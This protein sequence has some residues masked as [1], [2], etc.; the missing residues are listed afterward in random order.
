M[1]TKPD[2]SFRWLVWTLA[3]LG[4]AVDQVGKYGVFQYLHDEARQHGLTA[5]RVIIPPEVLRFHVEFKSEPFPEGAS[6]LQTWSGELQPR[7][8]KGAFLGFGNGDNG[9][10]NGNVIFAVVSVLAAGAIIWWSTRRQVARDW[11]LCVALG[12][13]LGGTL[14]N[15]YDR[16]VFAG[17]RDYLFWDYLF[18]T[19][20]F[21]IADFLLICGA[22]LLLVQ[23]F[24]GKPA[25]EEKPAGPAAEPAAQAAARPE[26]AEVK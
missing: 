10:R 19:A 22:G 23:A 24:I 2:R 3:F 15:L 26:M 1:N 11:L 8:N 21:N 17:V 16:I 12:L 9:G 13:I 5:E 25:K 14:G 18:K 20:V 7:V 4:F 6:W